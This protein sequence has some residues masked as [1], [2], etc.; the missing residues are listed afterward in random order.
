MR[1]LSSGQLALPLLLVLAGTLLMMDRLDMIRI[2]HLA[3]LWPV[4]LIAAGL[5]EL[6]TWATP[7]RN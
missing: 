2:D 6:Y 4:A 1:T 7:R 5:E 3:Q